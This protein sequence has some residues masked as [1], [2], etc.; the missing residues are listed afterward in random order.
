MD[1]IIA[2]VSGTWVSFLLPDKRRVGIFRATADGSS[3]IQTAIAGAEEG[4]HL[5]FDIPKGFLQFWLRT[6][7]LEDDGKTLTGHKRMR[8]EEC[9]AVQSL[10]QSVLVRFTSLVVSVV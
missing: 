7:S 1:S 6:V 2:T 3:V 10:A 9:T 8:A 5:T 4:K